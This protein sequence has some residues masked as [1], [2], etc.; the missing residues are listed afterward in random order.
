MPESVLVE[1]VRP[2]KQ[3]AVIHEE[4][5]THDAIPGNYAVDRARQFIVD[6]IA[7]RLAKVGQLT[8]QVCAPG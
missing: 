2:V 6:A 5:C 1:Q 4:R 3:Q 8:S 7:K